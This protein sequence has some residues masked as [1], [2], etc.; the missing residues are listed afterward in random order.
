[1]MEMNGGVIYL[2]FFILWVR[3][4]LN[5]ERKKK[6]SRIQNWKKQ[7]QYIKDDSWQQCEAGV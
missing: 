4:L 7:K 1:M 2:F 6:L 5:K 3:A